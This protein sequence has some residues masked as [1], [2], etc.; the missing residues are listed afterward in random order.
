MLSASLTSLALWTLTTTNIRRLAK[1]FVVEQTDTAA[2]TT[3]PEAADARPVT[4]ALD[5][6]VL[7]VVANAVAETLFPAADRRGYEQKKQKDRH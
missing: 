4:S 7:T 3:P 1:I 5:F 2:D 6:S